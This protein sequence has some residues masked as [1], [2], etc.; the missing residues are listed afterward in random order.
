MEYL[1]STSGCHKVN[2]LFLMI[3]KETTLERDDDEPCA[4]LV[5]K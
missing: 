1:V 5:K 4:D 3:I 2:I